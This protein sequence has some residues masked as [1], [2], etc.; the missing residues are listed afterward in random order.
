V[1][2]DFDFYA[3]LSHLPSEPELSLTLQALRKAGLQDAQD[4]FLKHC[5]RTLLGDL[6]LEFLI[7]LKTVSCFSIVELYVGLV[8]QFQQVFQH[9]DPMA[10]HQACKRLNVQFNARSFVEYLIGNKI[11]LEDL[12]NAFMDGMDPITELP[13]LWTQLW[14]T[15]DV[16][17]QLKRIHQ[18]KSLISKWKPLA[19]DA[20]CHSLSFVGLTHQEAQI[21]FAVLK[22]QTNPFHASYAFKD[23]IRILKS[24]PNLFH[25]IKDSD[26]LQHPIL[27]QCLELV[28]WMGSDNFLQCCDS[29]L[30][31][32]YSAIDC[33][34][35]FCKY[36][37]F[38]DST[39]SM[40]TAKFRILSLDLGMT[41]TECLMLMM[42]GDADE[43]W[44]DCL[45]PST[46]SRWIAVKKLE[47]FG[48]LSSQRDLSLALL[49]N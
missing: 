6:K 14:G 41:P 12:M 9:M 22:L 47:Y 31:R 17:A 25:L 16:G 37:T 34:R 1:N 18:V 10:F 3:F 26:I 24:S 35:T 11:Q 40:D 36:M 29:P 44:V 48:Q 45:F 7:Q 30:E 28:L 49:C 43:R 23:F 13:L 5:L 15:M 27:I 19:V 42:D 4:L 38:V 20:F 46:K 8:D 33:A 39:F 2:P 32:C 21:A